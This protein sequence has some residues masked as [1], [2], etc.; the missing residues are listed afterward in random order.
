MGHI[1]RTNNFD[2][3]LRD[4]LRKFGAS[5]IITHEASQAAT[6][7]IAMASPVTQRDIGGQDAEEACKPVY[8]GTV[9]LHDGENTY[10]VKE[11]GVMYGAKF[12]KKQDEVNNDLKYK[13]L[14]C[15]KGKKGSEKRYGVLELDHSPDECVLGSTEDGSKN[16]PAL[17][18][19]T[20][21]YYGDHEFAATR[22][23]KDVKLTYVLQD[24]TEHDGWESKNASSK[25]VKSIRIVKG[26]EKWMGL[27]DVEEL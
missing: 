18:V 23:G 11:E 14:D 7:A 22:E 2:K 8:R 3:D 4:V 16:A 6:M 10:G 27:A 1:V 26:N 19:G 5:K 12:V 15:K 25:L 20:C 17:I 9:V 13:F 24:G 21:G